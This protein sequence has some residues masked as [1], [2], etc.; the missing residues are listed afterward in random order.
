MTPAR[1]HALRPCK[2]NNPV[3][4][5]AP[6]RARLRARPVSQDPP[7]KPRQQPPPPPGSATPPAPPPG[8]APFP[9]GW[10][11]GDGTVQPKHSEA[12]APGVLTLSAACIPYGSAKS[13]MTH[14]SAG[15][16]R[17]RTCWTCSGQGRQELDCNMPI[18]VIFDPLFSCLE[19]NSMVRC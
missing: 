1:H 8:S 9:P 10:R 14:G 19:Y 15:V 5:A 3:G 17:W 18:Q 4:R 2:H 12:R 11:L 16:G 6:S 7:P 13:T